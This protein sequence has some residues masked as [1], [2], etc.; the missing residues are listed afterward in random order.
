VRLLR[1]LKTPGFACEA[2]VGP[3]AVFVR[4]ALSSIVLLRISLVIELYSVRRGLRF[5]L[6][7]L[8]RALRPRR[9]SRQLVL[10]PQL[11]PRRRL[12]RGLR[13]LVLCA[14]RVER[15]ALFIRAAADATR[16][17][18]ADDAGRLLDPLPAPR[19][20]RADLFPVGGVDAG[21]AVTRALYPH[22]IPNS[23][24]ASGT[25]PL[26]KVNQTSI[27]TQQ[28]TPGAYSMRRRRAV[29][30]SPKWTPAHEALAKVLYVRRL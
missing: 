21:D 29:A 6:G 2:F 18:A 5:G 17:A 28:F 9:I 22:R 20:A 13:R 11:E 23:G 15:E 10:L 4:P 7:G 27:Y 16:A 25:I 1:Y 12:G 19:R 26:R 3:A 30:S 14:H 8:R 24:D